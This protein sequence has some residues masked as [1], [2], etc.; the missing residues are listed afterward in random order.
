MG[1]GKGHNRLDF[2]AC[3]LIGFPEIIFFTNAH[4]F[5]TLSKIKGQG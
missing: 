1:N 3:S 4:N 2:Q 5:F